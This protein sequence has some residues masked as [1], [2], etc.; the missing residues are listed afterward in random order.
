MFGFGKKKEEAPIA[1]PEPRPSVW[2]THTFDSPRQAPI[3]IDAF[4]AELAQ[5]QPAHGAFAQD[6]SSDGFSTF[7]ALNNSPTNISEVLV[8][9][10]A[11]QSFIGHQ[12][13]GILAQHWLINKACSMPADDAIRKGFNTVSTDGE[14]LAEK[15]AKVIKQYDKSMRLN[16]NLREFIRKGR[17]FGIRIMMFKV[18]STDPK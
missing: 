17:I 2:S 7:K 14:E 15:T 4:I 3:D 16:Q 5:A 9:W 13:A 1:L 12:L 6:D 11:S 8:M 18:E 10:Y